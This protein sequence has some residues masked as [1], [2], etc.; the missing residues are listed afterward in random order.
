MTL[1]EKSAEYNKYRDSVKQVVEFDSFIF[2][3]C[4]DVDYIEGNLS[5]KTWT[6]I[7]GNPNVS[8]F[9]MTTVDLMPAAATSYTLI[10]TLNPKNFKTYKQD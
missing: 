1:E 2:K 8:S 6:K 7:S 10:T 9:K 3:Y 4:W 5:F